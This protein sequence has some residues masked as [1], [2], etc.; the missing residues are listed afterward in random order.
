M[1][2]ANEY[3]NQDVFWA[4][5][6]GGGGTFG[7]VTQA[8]VRIYPDD[9]AVVITVSISTPLTNK[10]E[11]W[12][13]GVA[14]LLTIL[15]TF[16]KENSSGQFVVQ[17]S[18]GDSLEAS[19][20]LYHIN[21][22]SLS[23]VEGRVNTYMSSYQGSKISYTL[24]SRYQARISS[25]LRKAPDKYP[26]D[27]G[28]LS[29]TMLVSN[30]LFNSPGGP[31]KIAEGFSRLRIGPKDIL[32]T[33]NLGGRVNVNK[34]HE[35]SSMH[36]KWR[37]SAHLITY[38]RAVEPSLDGKLNA[39]EDLATNQLPLL[40]SIEDSSFR[41]SYVNIGSVDQPDSHLVYWGKDNYERL[42]RI[43]R[44]V[45]KD[46]LFITKLGIGSEN[47]DEQGMCRK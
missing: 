22:T 27:H 16:N 19:L 4:L 38:V 41:V 30:N 43:K 26:K 7:V 11:F 47:W 29:G 45:D 39:L 12:V 5:R 34:E 42:S 36:P 20:T 46:D 21:V 24:S 31:L 14:S 32:F 44:K 40:F 35:F 3:R 25:E 23:S 10:E 33:S 13:K 37:E 2:T 1:L 8:T 17:H 9:P 18:S 6:G 15:Q 28:I